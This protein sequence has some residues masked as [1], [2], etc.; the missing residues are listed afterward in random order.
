MERM[1]LTVSQA[2]LEPWVLLVTPVHRVF[3][4][5]R[6]S[7]DLPALRA[8]VVRRVLSVLR[9]TRASRE[10]RVPWVPW[11]RNLFR[12]A[13]TVPVAGLSWEEVA[14][15]PG[16]S[17]HPSRP[18]SPT[19]SSGEDMCSALLLSPS[20]RERTSACVC[21]TS[22]LAFTGQ[23]MVEISGSTSTAPAPSSLATASPLASLTTLP[24]P[25]T[26]SLPTELAPRGSGWVTLTVTSRGPTTAPRPSKLS[27]GWFH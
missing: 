27:G 18:H 13:A 25:R 19:A 26:A 23:R 10:L 5:L 17:L 9:E 20:L 8:F 21:R 11:G 14:C 7:T 3:R 16:Q 6:V 15:R 22:G 24:V 2:S 4:D 12:F 1:E